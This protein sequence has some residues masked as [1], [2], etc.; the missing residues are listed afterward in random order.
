MWEK[1]TNS[2]TTA[3]LAD[4]QCKLNTYSWTR[5]PHDFLQYPPSG[6]LYTD[7]LE[8]LNDLKTSNDGTATPCFASHCDWRIPGIGELRSILLAPNPDCTTSPCIDPAFGPTLAGPF[9]SSNSSAGNPGF[10]WSVSFIDGLVYDNN[11]EFVG[12]YARAVRS[13]R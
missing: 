7:F 1:K 4:P 8:R 2:C 9:W 11:V 12:G 10:A 6:T 13:G 5:T 3:D